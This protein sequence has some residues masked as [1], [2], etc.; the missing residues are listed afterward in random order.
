MPPVD[1]LEPGHIPGQNP[2]TPERL[3]GEMEVGA[4]R[5]HA[6]YLAVIGVP[7]ALI[8]AVAAIYLTMEV[9]PRTRPAAGTAEQ[10]K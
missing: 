1:P 9:D 3:Q 6:W 5:S 8:I 10:G 4:T 7:L 2:N